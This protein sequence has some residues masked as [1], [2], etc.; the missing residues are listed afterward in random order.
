MRLLG[1]GHS[2]PCP[3]SRS[4]SESG[5]APKCTGLQSTHRKLIGQR[6]TNATT[7]HAQRVHER[8]LNS[9]STPAATTFKWCLLP[10][11]NG[12]STKRGHQWHRKGY[13]H[14]HEILVTGETVR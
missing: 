13:W 9:T 7:D 10:L 14:G 1:D 8:P 12:L 4:S 11:D 6:T 5:K 3:A 2:T